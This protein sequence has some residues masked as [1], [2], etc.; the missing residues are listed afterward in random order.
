MFN[1][2]VSEKDYVNFLK[3]IISIP[4]ETGSEK[5]LA[6]FFKKSLTD[7]AVK[8]TFIDGCGNL[9]SVIRGTEKGPDIL[10][11]GH[12]DTVPPGNKND[13]LPYDPYK[14]VIDKD[15]NLYGRGASDMKG[16]LAVLYF[17]MLYFQKLQEKG[18]NL[19]GS[20]IFSAVVHE[21]AAEMLGMEYLFERTMPENN[22]RCDVVFLAEPTNGDLA[23]GQRGKIEL[24]V[25]TYGRTAHSSVPAEGVNALEKMLPVIEYVFNKMPEKMK[26]NPFFGDGTVTITDCTV[27]PG[28]LS[29]IPDECEISVDRRY[30]PDE[31]IDSLMD[32]FNNLFS[33]LKKRDPDFKA[34]VFPRIYEE[35]SY[36]GY[37]KKVKKYHPPWI[38]P[39]NNL[40][41]QKSIQALKNAGQN[42]SLKYWKSGCDASMSCGIHG[43]PSIGY[44]WGNEKYVHKAQERVNIDQM[45]KTI[46]GYVEII[47]TIMD[48]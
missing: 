2:I 16:G 42:P 24:V 27:Q 41:V 3:E 13:W 45:L 8:E 1:N 47:K 21:E 36:S 35:K 46:E 48:I 18:I 32:E 44:S 34:E 14:A 28:K 5:L 43:I 22:L 25:K 10:L 7:N 38:L 26:S 12:L 11:N 17:V 6:D 37:I 39:E 23:I 4:S 40:Y 15:N 29:V 30:M 19:P 20:L 31:S 33:E 9:V